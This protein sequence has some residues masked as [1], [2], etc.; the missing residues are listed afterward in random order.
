MGN[1]ALHDHIFIKPNRTDTNFKLD[2]G[3]QANVLPDIMVIA[4]L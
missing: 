2:M 4:F 1:I 3:V